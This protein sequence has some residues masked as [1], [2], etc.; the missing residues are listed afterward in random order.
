MK[1]GNLKVSNFPCQRYV[2]AAN[3]THARTHTHTHT[4]TRNAGNLRTFH[5]RKRRISPKV[6]SS[7]QYIF[8]DDMR[9]FLLLQS[10]LNLW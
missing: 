1:S 3:H 2:N 10:F 9:Q 8:Y 5:V 4:Q 7:A 6:V